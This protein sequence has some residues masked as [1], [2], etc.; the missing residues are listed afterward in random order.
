MFKKKKKILHLRYSKAVLI[1]ISPSWTWIFLFQCFLMLDFSSVCWRS[2]YVCVHVFLKSLE[3]PVLNEQL[4]FKNIFSLNQA[5]LF[6]RN[7]NDL[8]LIH[9]IKQKIIQLI[10][11]YNGINIIFVIKCLPCYNISWLQLLPCFFPSNLP[12]QSSA[13]REHTDVDLS[14]KCFN[15]IISFTFLFFQ[16]PQNWPHSHPL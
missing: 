1:L 13:V 3:T 8:D 15:E 7:M 16:S 2:T 14:V 11:F 5:K 10:L 4:I 9:W 6:L 12:E